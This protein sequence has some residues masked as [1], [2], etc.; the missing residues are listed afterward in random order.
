M[1][2]VEEELR[3][4]PVGGFDLLALLLDLAEPPGVLN[5]WS[6]RNSAKFKISKPIINSLRSYLGVLCAFAGDNS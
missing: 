6:G 5:R 4:L 3:L 2:H 1:G